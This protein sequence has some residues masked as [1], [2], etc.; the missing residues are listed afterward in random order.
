MISN[1]LRL[2]HAGTWP[3][4][5]SNSTIAPN[6]SCIT[7][8]AYAGKSDDLWINRHRAF[9]GVE[10]ARSISPTVSWTGRIAAERHMGTG[11]PD[12]NRYR[13]YFRMLI[14]GD[15]VRPCLQ[16]ELLAVRHGF[17]SISNS[18]G[19]RFRLASRMTAEQASCTITGKRSGAATMRP[20]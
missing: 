18:A 10:T 20:W 2:T 1:T 17:H 6:S 3:I 12:Y 7:G 8:S 16:N 13:S 19:L 4:R 5:R 15:R 9:T 11:R 14:G